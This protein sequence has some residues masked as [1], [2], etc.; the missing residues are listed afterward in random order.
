MCSCLFQVVI[1]LLEAGADM[2]LSN[3]RGDTPLGMAVK[4]GHIEIAHALVSAGAEI[5]PEIIGL[6]LERGHRELAQ[7]LAAAD[8]GSGHQ[9][10]PP[11]W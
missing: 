10:T 2:N 11:G 5:Q 7:F 4:R 8:P 9:R 3:L 1:L 6:A